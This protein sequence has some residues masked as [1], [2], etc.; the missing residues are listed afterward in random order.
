MCR[1]GDDVIFIVMSDGIV[2][3]IHQLG[4]SNG[5]G[6]QSLTKYCLYILKGTLLDSGIDQ[7]RGV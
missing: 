2:I 1:I 6:P 5:Y 3:G 4:E 7:R